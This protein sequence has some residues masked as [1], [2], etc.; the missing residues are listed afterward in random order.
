M[1]ERREQEGALLPR[2]ARWR[3]GLAALRPGLG[4]VKA[5]EA[6]LT[7]VREG[8]KGCGSSRA[9]DAG[10]TAGSPGSELEPR[11]T[12]SEGC[13]HREPHWSPGGMVLWMAGARG[14]AA[15]P[16]ASL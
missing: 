7:A 6:L 5:A 10:P 11:R 14:A 15:G 9:R 1:A 12:E 16:D 3:S 8:R 13:R 4:G 2:T